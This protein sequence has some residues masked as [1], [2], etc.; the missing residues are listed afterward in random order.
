MPI[1]KKKIVNNPI[2][3]YK[4]IYHRTTYPGLY[5]DVSTISRGTCEG[6]LGHLERGGGGLSLAHII[7]ICKQSTGT[8]LKKKYDLSE[9]EKVKI[10]VHTID[11][12]ILFSGE[13]NPAKYRYHIT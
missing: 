5:T 13:I 1:L 8:H 10:I 2:F 6:V 7:S 3:K 9:T 11:F 12:R 4:K